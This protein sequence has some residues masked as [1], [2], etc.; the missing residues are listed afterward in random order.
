[1]RKPPILLV[2]LIIVIIIVLIFVL[3]KKPGV[4]SRD[5]W[6][7]HLVETPDEVYRRSDGRFDEAAR[8]ALRRTLN[9]TRPTAD[10]HALAATILRRNLIAQE[11]KVGEQPTDD[12]VKRSQLRREMFEETRRHYAAALHRLTE[13]EEK[14]VHAMPLV[15]ER[16]PMQ[17]PHPHAGG[18]ID[19]VVD[20]AVFGFG[21]LI[22]NDPLQH[23]FGNDRMRDNMNLLRNA[24]NTRD[25][26]I[27]QR[28]DIVQQ[29]IPK[30]LPA[31]S[32]LR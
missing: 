8:I 31:M 1:M 10:D 11:N 9:K 30:S 21:D 3:A 23:F 26:V 17:V 18:I 7:A 19:A 28:R 27:K 2:A 22:A 15:F 29:T 4:L 12:D 16:P 24:R 32:T 13:D 20:F 14:P 6:K 25:T 5:Y